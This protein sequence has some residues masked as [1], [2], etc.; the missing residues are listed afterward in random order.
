MG[1]GWSLTSSHVPHNQYGP[2]WPHFRPPGQV[3]PRPVHTI[4]QLR[5]A[6]SKGMH[7]PSPASV[8]QLSSSPSGQPCVQAPFGE[9]SQPAPLAAPQGLPAMEQ[10]A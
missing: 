8:L 6:P 1:V 2:H 3:A 5:P 9:H 4:A 7:A 10:A